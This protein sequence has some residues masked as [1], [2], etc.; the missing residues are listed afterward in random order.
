[1]KVYHFSEDPGIEEFVPRPVL[2]PSQ[3]PPGM[4]WLNGPFVWAVDE[5]RQGAYLFP[6]DCPRI[7]VWPTK[8]TIP[9][10]R[11]RWFGG[12]SVSMIAHVERE[13]LE[14][15]RRAT[16]YRYEFDAAGFE[17]LPGDDWMAVSRVPQRPTSAT[18]IKD[19]LAALREAN[20]ELRVMQSLE[21]LRH[22]WDSTMH[23]SGIR[24]RNAHSWRG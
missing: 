24:L 6:R 14:R 16:V 12:R 20:V 3:R 5:L 22:A 19:L 8:E 17:T 2:V 1:M 7:L 21:P 23:V 18:E 9:Q 4:D 13:W 11:E 10:D 15:I